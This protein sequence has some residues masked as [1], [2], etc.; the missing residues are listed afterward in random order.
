MAKDEET[1]YSRGKDGR[2][3]RRKVRKDGWS[4]RRR[5]IFLDHYAATG[6]ASEACRAAGMSEGAA[7]RLR[8]RDP[9]FAAQ[10]DE[11]HAAAMVRLEGLVVQFAETGGR[12]VP[13][14]PGEVP[15]VDL[16]NFDPEL[17]LKV[18]SRRRPTAHGFADRCGARPRRAGKAELVASLRR[19]VAAV[20]KD[21]AK[22]AGA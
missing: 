11:A 16:T 20:K 5:A 2:A 10:Y 1:F 17:A 3:Q 18:L 21:R 4:G 7:S 6:N 9:E 8:R 22:R 13:V 15:R 19:L 12:T 14:E